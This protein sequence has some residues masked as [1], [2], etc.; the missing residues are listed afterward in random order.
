MKRALFLSVPLFFLVACQS[1]ALT[2]SPPKGSSLLP[3]LTVNDSCSAYTT[4]ADCKSAIGKSAGT[5]FPGMNV[6]TWTPVDACPA[7]ASCPSGVCV[8]TNSCASLTSASACQAD[9]GCIWSAVVATPTASALCP[10]GQSCDGGGFCFER[11][12]AV[13]GCFCVQPLAC[14]ANGSC[15]P[16][17]CDCPPPQAADGGER[18]RRRNL[19]LRLPSLRRRRGL[20]RL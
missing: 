4:S 12:S 9:S 18:G 15:P 13:N 8:A 14:P 10:V 3:A 2:P 11:G 20:P 7:G 19:H 17:Q 1:Q 6:C 16:V 5:G